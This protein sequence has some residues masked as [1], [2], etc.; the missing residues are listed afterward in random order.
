MCKTL[1]VEGD[2]GHCLE[3]LKSGAKD[4]RASIPR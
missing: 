3:M 1:D 2:T 4:L